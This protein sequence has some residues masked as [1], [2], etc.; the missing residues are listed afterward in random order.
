[1]VA[2]LTAA[3]EG[4]RTWD[5]VGGGAEKRSVLVG[6]ETEVGSRGGSEVAAPCGTAV[7]AEAEARSRCDA[8]EEAEARARRD[9]ACDP[10]HKIE[11]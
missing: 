8:D 9:G 3:A 7:G 1:M 4:A 2:I 10:T 6:D 11:N 5:F